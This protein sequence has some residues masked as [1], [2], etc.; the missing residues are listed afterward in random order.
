MSDLI[1]KQCDNCN[2]S[3]HYAELQRIDLLNGFDVQFKIMCR[4][5]SFVI[6]SKIISKFDIAEFIRNK[7]RE[8]NKWNK[9]SMQV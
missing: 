2:M 4:R 6:A 9:K 7:E 1:P 3:C 5:K 8:I